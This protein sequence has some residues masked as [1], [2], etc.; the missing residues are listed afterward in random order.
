MSKILKYLIAAIVSL[1]ALA[2]IVPA[3]IPAETYKTQ[4]IAA[5][6]RS[7]SRTLTIDGNLA[8]QFRP[9][10]EFSIEDV[11]L[12]N[13][14]GAT[15][16]LM[17]QMARMTI[18]VDW[19]AFLSRRI[20]ITK[21]VLEE[22]V[23]SLEVMKDGT[24]N[25][26]FAPTTDA[27][28]DQESSDESTRSQ[29]QALDAISFGDLR[30][31]GGRLV[32]RNHHAGQTWDV[33][34]VN[35]DIVLP[36]LKGE[37]KVSGDL[38]YNNE[39]LGLALELG[40][41][42]AITSGAETAF[43]LALTSRLMSVQLD[44]S[45]TGGAASKIK[46]RANVKVPSVR[47]LAQWTG[48]PIAIEKGFG[49]FAIEGDLFAS[50]SLYSFTNATLA[51]DDMNGTGSLTVKNTGTRPIVSGRL[52][53]NKIDLR[54]YMNAPAESEDASGAIEELAWSKAPIDFS[55]LKAL[56]V[57][58][59]LKS[60][61]LHFLDYEI[62]N[63]EL[64]LIVRNNILTADLTRMDLYGGTGTGTVSF[65]TNP[66]AA[67]AKATFT[68]NNI[69]AAPL[70]LAASG[71][72]IIEGKGEFSFGVNT[73]GKSQD[74][75]MRN[76]SGKGALMLRD[77]KLKGVNLN[78]M[79]QILSAFTPRQQAAP[80]QTEATTTAQTGTG[81]STDFVEMGG[82]FNIASGVLRT[83]DFALIN[84]ALSLA[85]QGRVDLGNQN[86][87]MK[88]APG[89]RQDDGGTN[90]KMK[91]QGPWNNITYAPDFEDI[92][93]GGL[94]DLI[95]GDTKDKEPT[96]EGEVAKQLLDAIFGPKR[97]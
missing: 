74:A 59:A 63:T 24:A 88:L 30:I 91:V 6:E 10:M 58:F 34:N 33:S 3:L 14:P 80:S 82:T 28:T 47:Q 77:G 79:L 51:F 25:W 94:R 40:S 29:R 55:G 17:A 11:T 15:D 97:K 86:I 20:A 92:I 42:E 27:V 26:E 67:K 75:L 73:T 49:P 52:T 95:L 57:N 89:K 41:L 46:A 76:L 22:P 13:A 90:L 32:W 93:K 60:Q 70:M 45:L 54:P 68:L 65:D 69:N 35:L 64:N 4:I 43:K 37:A 78:R 7:T 44:G 5:V 83:S 8:L 23:I 50:G 1:V 87:D 61:S 84:D 12:S 71:K 38:T 66:A 56:E 9:G 36:D 21:F 39:D 19:R 62:G 48:A 85:G 18:G 96:L 72:D 31:V 16:D 53:L 2:F 81:K